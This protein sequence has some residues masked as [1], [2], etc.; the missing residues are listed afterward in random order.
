[1]NFGSSRRNF[2]AGSL[3][4]PV[5]PALA[6][7]PAKPIGMARRTLGKTGLKLSPLG[8]GGRGTSEAG[9]L[10]RAFDLGI[11]Y[12]DTGRMYAN[13]ERLI[14]V[15]LKD[16]RKD[17]VISTKTANQTKDKALADLDTS[18]KELQSDYVDIWQ[19]QNAYTRPEDVT[20]EVLET[21]QI[22]KKAGKARFVGITSHLNVPAMVDNMVK[23]GGCDMMLVG[24]N[25]TMQADTAHAIE[26]A[27]QS[28][29]GMVAIKVLA[30]GFARIQKSLPRS[31]GQ[32]YTP[33]S[34]DSMVM[35]LKQD[36]AMTAG[37]RWVLRNEF[38]D[39]SAVCMA[40]Y[41]QVESNVRAMAQAFTPEDEKLLTAKTAFL[42]PRYCRMCG[43]CTGVCDK[44]VR[45]SDMLRFVAYAE[46][47][48]DFPLAR[49]SYLDLP[50]HQRQIHCGN[51]G[52]CT[53]N[54]PNGVQVRDQLLK[55]ERLFA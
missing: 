37:I 35:T 13:S 20:D 10:R 23:R 27:R 15:A 52:S 47:Y 30:G 29:M 5:L 2:L 33:G 19:Y 8:F 24:F 26:R 22:A 40:D 41:D 14:G 11:N 17:V 16:H 54:C 34:I 18:L 38:V 32:W 3:A 46:G 6:A 1:M 31:D 25:F 7:P 39:S 50:E 55:A 12:F 4:L 36:G 53:V 43:T 21:L 51:C 49:Q 28:G 44:G 9:V 45:V 48:R 42:A